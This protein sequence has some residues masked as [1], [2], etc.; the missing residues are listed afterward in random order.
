MTHERQ[1]DGNHGEALSVFLSE[2]RVVLL[3]R[4]RVR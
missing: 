4:L 2:A 1:P 3:R